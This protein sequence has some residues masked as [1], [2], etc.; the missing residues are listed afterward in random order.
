MET[1]GRFGIGVTLTAFAGFKRLNACLTEC[2]HRYPNAGIER[3]VKHLLI[4]HRCHTVTLK[5][6]G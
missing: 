2:F 4:G 1:N 5:D 6:H 3:G